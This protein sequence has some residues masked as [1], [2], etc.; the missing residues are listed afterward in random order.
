[1]RTEWRPEESGLGAEVES[2]AAVALDVAYRVHSAFGP[3]ALESVYRRALSL[4]LRRA[5]CHV[6]EEVW[7]PL[8]FEGEIIPHALRADMV[9]NG[10]LVVEV[11]ATNDFHPAHIR[12]TVSY[13]RLGDYPLG[14][15]MNFGAARFKDGF[16]RVPN[17]RPVAPS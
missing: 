1:M 6:A 4:G 9:I 15:L 5:G 10:H 2:T 13:V 11:K 17:R 8:T 3:G 7:L 14:I 16:Y 12:Q